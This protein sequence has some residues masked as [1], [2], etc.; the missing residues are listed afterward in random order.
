M[1]IFPA[2]YSGRSF[3]MD[4]TVTNPDG[5]PYDL[6]DLQ[7]AVCSL[8]AGT[9]DDD[10]DAIA[11]WTLDSEITFQDDDPATGVLQ[12]RVTPE[13]MSLVSVSGEISFYWIAMDILTDGGDEYNIVDGLLPVKF[14]T[15]QVL[16]ET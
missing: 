4:V 5:T 9:R 10:E 1:E 7:A 14:P 3:A 16:L 11:W 2:V 12:L 15:N 8:K 13:N 6:T